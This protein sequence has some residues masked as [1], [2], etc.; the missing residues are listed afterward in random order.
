LTLPNKNYYNPQNNPN[1]LGNYMAGLIK[2]YQKCPKCQAPFPSSKGDFPIICKNGCHT[3]PTKYFIALKWKGKKEHLYYDRDGR[4][5][6][7][8]GQVVAVIGEIRSLMASHKNGRG[9]FDPGAYK[10]QSATSF[11]NLWK[12]FL[13]SYKGATH[14]KIRAIGRHH[15]DYFKDFQM[16]DIVPLHI[17]KWWKGIVGKGLSERYMNDILT[18]A[19]AF[20]RYAYKLDVILKVPSVLEGLSVKISAPDVDGWLTEDQQLAVLD[21]VPAYDRPIFDFLFL[22]GCRVNEA[23]ALQTTDIEGD[24]IILRNT[25]KRDRSIGPVKNKKPRRVPYQGDIKE[26][27]EAALKVTSIGDKFVFINKWGRRYH[28]DYL[29]NTFYDALDALEIKRIKLKNATRHS[30]GM[31]LLD[32]GY[33]YWQVS[34]IM[35]HSDT[36]VTEHYVKMRE[37]AKSQAYGRSKPTVVKVTNK[38]G[39]KRGQD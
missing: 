1:V 39:T 7:N 13:D 12:D 36:R 34:K 3:Q 33:D 21:K 26:C 17:D 31:G 18:W 10:K 35:N 23:C 6:L 27:I 28:D 15:M 4:Q 5:I 14:D 19:K 29:R 16:R 37:S 25:V 11:K 38:R 24:L 9:F 32:K 2:S 30:F 22:T 20:F 8:W